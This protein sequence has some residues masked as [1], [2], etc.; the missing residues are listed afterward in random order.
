MEPVPLRGQ[1]WWV[2]VGLVEHKRFVIVQVLRVDA[3]VRAAQAL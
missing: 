2:D 1:I 3:A